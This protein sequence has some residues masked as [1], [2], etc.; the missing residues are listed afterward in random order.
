MIQDTWL[1]TNSLVV[2]IDRAK[3]SKA[4]DAL[5]QHSELNRLD[6]FP[7]SWA[8]QEFNGG[9]DLWGGQSLTIGRFVQ[10]FKTVLNLPKCRI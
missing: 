8:Y 6:S 7:R 2:W 4:L 3:S 1:E 10:R 9:L 5:R